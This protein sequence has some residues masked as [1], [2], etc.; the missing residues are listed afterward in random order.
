MKP[1]KPQD[2][3]LDAY[4]QEIEDGLARGEYVSTGDL[5][6][7]KAMFEEAAA[8]YRQL[9]TS[10]RVTIRVNQSDLIK[11]KAKAVKH[12]IPYQTL[13]NALI[14]QYAEVKMQIRL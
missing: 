8:N 10:K 2:I 7:V 5:D 14:H 6:S 13:L 4:E 11:V 12:Q 1:I 3:K 9:Q